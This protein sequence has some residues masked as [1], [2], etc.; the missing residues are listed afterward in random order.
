[1]AAALS[2][3]GGFL[4]VV[5]AC[6]S[7]DSSAGCDDS[8]CKPG[9]KCLPLAGETKCRKTCAS[10]DNPETSCPAGYTCVQ[11]DDTSIP[12]FCVQDNAVIQTKP[13]QWGAQCN[14]SEH[15]DNPKCDGSQEFYCYATSPTDGNA[16]CTRFSC[17][18]DRDCAAGYWCA[19]VNVGPS[20]D[21]SKRSEHQTQTVCLK[22][23]YGAAC[24]FDLDCPSL[25]GRTQHCAQDA[26][27]AGFCT[28]ECTNATNCNTEARCVD[29]GIGPKVCYPRSNLI[30]G[31]GSLCSPCRSDADCGDDGICVKGQY[32]TEQACAKKAPGDC[33]KGQAR[34]GCVQSLTTPK[35]NIYCPGGTLNEVLPNYC[36][37][38]YEVGGNPSDVGCWTPNR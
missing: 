17:Q 6:K 36:I 29:I 1:M 3:F 27:G 22:R 12:A 23:T 35:V 15:S 32:T 28:P 20:A 2:L 30:V 16:I 25:D 11:Q 4:G 19:T 38:L 14:P 8:V 34:G 13:G 7:D 10:N 31:D 33:Q 9:N 24:K 21:T 18:T 26:N 37:G 5:S